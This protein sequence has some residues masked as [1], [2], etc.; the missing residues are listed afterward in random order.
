MRKKISMAFLRN[1]RMGKEQTILFVVQNSTK[2][3][4]R[5]AGAVK[6]TPNKSENEKDHLIPIKLAALAPNTFP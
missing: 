2:E 6:L 3:V 5:E 4:L 1:G